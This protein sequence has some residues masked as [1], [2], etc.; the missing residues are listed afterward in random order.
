MYVYL[1]Y[2]IILY[3]CFSY[4]YAITKFELNTNINFTISIRG[5]YCVN[6][7]LNI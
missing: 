1:L 6:I 3:I 7:E 4:N 5:R 2:I